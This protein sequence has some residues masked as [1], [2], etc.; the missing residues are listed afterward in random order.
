MHA[1]GLLTCCILGSP[2]SFG[3]SKVPRHLVL[4][5][6][7][8]SPFNP[9][10]LGNSP[11][12]LLQWNVSSTAPL[13]TSSEAKVLQHSSDETLWLH[14][15]LSPWLLSVS[16]ECELLEDRGSSFSRSHYYWLPTQCSFPPLSFLADPHFVRV[17]IVLCQNKGRRSHPRGRGWVLKSKPIPGPYFLASNWLGYGHVTKFWSMTHETKSPGELLRK[18]FWILRDTRKRRFFCWLWRSL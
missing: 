6:C 1:T 3:F 17:P 2:D 5:A 8:I 15:C 11:L 7:N 4:S 12:S 10:W 9:T 18:V 14:L 16:L 13:T